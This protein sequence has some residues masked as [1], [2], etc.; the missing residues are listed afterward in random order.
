MDTI[1]HLPD[2][3][4][5]LSPKLNET[6]YV[7]CTVKEN[8]TGKLY[9]KAIMHFKE[10]EGHTFIFEKS[11]ADE[12]KLAYKSLFRKI[13]LEV[14]SDLHSVGLIAAISN[15]LA[16]NGIS[17]NPVSA[18]YHDHLFIPDL[19]AD[20]AFMLIKSIGIKNL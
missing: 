4:R 8:N 12:L 10:D 15:L 19:Q 6:F 18:Y 5:N 9:E 13:T 3:L 14:Y 17:V 16:E 7:F 11:V 20:K 1:T 2:I